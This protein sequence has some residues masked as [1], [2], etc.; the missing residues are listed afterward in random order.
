MTRIKR[1]SSGM[2]PRQQAQNSTRDA[3]AAHV[4]TEDTCRQCATGEAIAV[5]MMLARKVRTPRQERLS[6]VGVRAIV[7]LQWDSAEPL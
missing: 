5:G 4:Q 2:P 3:H 7:L 6:R 1:H